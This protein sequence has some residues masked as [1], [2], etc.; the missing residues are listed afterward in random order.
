MSTQ[1]TSRSN[2]AGQTQNQTWGYH[3][4]PLTDATYNM[5]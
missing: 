4:T 3:D 1:N 5:V 2:T